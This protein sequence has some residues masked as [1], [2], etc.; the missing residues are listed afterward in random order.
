MPLVLTESSS[1]A[2][3][4]VMNLPFQY[5][6]ETF[7]KVLGSHTSSPPSVVTQAHVPHLVGAEF[8]I[9]RASQIH[10]IFI[11]TCVIF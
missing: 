3:K 11:L 2:T 5:L 4:M 8:Q 9:L 6:S 7:L 1:T 10:F